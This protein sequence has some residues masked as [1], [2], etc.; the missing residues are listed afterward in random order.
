MIILHW[1][2]HVP[3]ATRV[4]VLFGVGL[5][6]RSILESLVS[7]HSPKV[8][9]LPFTWGASSRDQ[10]SELG[11]IQAAILETCK[12]DLRNC[13]VDIIWS[14]GRAGFG[15]GSEAFDGELLSFKAVVSMCQRLA[16]HLPENDQVKL[17]LVSS[18]GGLFEGLRQVGLHDEPSPRR[19]YGHA[20]LAQEYALQ[21]I[22]EGIPFAIY[23][24]SSVYGY[25]GTRGRVGLIAALIDAALRN[26]TAVI[27]GYQETLRDFVFVK[28]IGRFIAERIS[29]EKRESQICLLASGR[30]TSVYEVVSLVERV[31]GLRLALRFVRGGN[32]ILHN[33][34]RPSALS[35]HWIPTSLEIGVATMA[36]QMRMQYFSKFVDN[37]RA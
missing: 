2:S 28:D 9:T 7:R 19:P 15:D 36:A 11:V 31:M 6:G 33:S 16:G 13:W 32:N 24:P 3:P 12:V 27:F 35:S 23:R 14:A 20:K 5:I 10:T 4:V 30:P 22:K 29:D 26:D 34:Y 37:E 17:H 21:A 18:A 8:A 1:R 25:G